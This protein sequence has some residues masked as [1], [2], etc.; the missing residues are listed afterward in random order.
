[1]KL[2]DSMFI[3]A[4]AVIFCTVNL[5]T[6]IGADTG[7][8]GSLG[9]G[10][11][12]P[13]KQKDQFNEEI[14][15]KNGV[16]VK[17]AMGYA[18]QIVPVI[19]VR[20]ELELAYR[21]YSAD[22]SNYNGNSVV[23]EGDSSYLSGMANGIL[24]FKT[25]TKFT[26]YIGIGLGASRVSWNTVKQPGASTYIDD[27]DTVFAYQGIVGLA[28]DIKPE[29]KIELEYRY[30]H[31]KDVSVRNS[32]GVQASIDGNTNHSFLIGVRYFF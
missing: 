27:S 1:M 13:D 24:D 18:W 20:A 21:T 19:Q 3:L 28:Y 14:V 25:G 29:L 4:T 10:Y 6:A 15:F 31:A 22:K 26:P 7:F 17:G 16:L 30:F 11:S 8:Y 12:I 2:K 32:T 9:I 23:L 5:S